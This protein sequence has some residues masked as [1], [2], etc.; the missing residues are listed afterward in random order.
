M[1]LDELFKDI[2]ELVEHSGVAGVVQ[3]D[4][5]RYTGDDRLY[6]TR[7]LTSQRRHLRV[8][9]IADRGPYDFEV[10]AGASEPGVEGRGLGDGDYV[11]MFIRAWII[12][13]VPTE[14]SGSLQMAFMVKRT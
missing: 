10:F 9:P 12:D 1:T 3:V 11:L 7:S 6:V 8:T 4:R 5:R 13:V 2:L 14:E